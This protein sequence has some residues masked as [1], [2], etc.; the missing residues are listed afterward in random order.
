MHIIFCNSN[1]SD[2]HISMC[3]IVQ[4][5]SLTLFH[6]NILFAFDC[7]ERLFFFFIF[8]FLFQLLVYFSFHSIFN[9]LF[10]LRLTERIHSPRVMLNDAH[11]CCNQ[12][13]AQ[14]AFTIA[15]AHVF[16][17]F[18]SPKGN[19]EWDFSF[20]WCCSLLHIIIFIYR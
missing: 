9:Y 19:N 15:Q 4:W 20:C 6:L 5:H 14:I 11:V 1:L 17:F 8:I 18:A 2:L 3:A 10:L 13:A 16:L 12:I 7:I